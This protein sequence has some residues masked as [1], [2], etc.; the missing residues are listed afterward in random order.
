MAKEAKFSEKPSVSG[1]KAK[2]ESN[3]IS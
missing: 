3:E 2:E 1:V